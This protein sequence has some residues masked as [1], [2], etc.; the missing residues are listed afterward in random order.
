MTVVNPGTTATGMRDHQ[1]L[2]PQTPDITEEETQR[3][4]DAITEMHGSEAWQTVLEEQGWTDAFVTGDDFT[5][6]LESES[7]R[8]EG[9]LGEL[10]LT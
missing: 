1:T 5:E 9:V 7:E 2:R 8:V 4:I 3:L 10:G 6:F